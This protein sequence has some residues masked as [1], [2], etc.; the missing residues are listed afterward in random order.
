[1]LLNEDL[2]R[3][4]WQDM[5]SVWTYWGSGTL[6]PCA[7]ICEQSPWCCL[8]TS[9]QS[10][11][12]SE[13]KSLPALCCQGQ[14]DCMP[15]SRHLGEIL[16]QSKQLQGALWHDQLCWD[17]CCHWQKYLKFKDKLHEQKKNTIP[18]SS[19]SLQGLVFLT[20]VTP[21]LSFHSIFSPK[22]IFCLL[23]RIFKQD[24]ICN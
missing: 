21:C 18:L 1:M 24:Q 14:R 19:N 15:H 3:W 5:K 8:S 23:N 22:S 17:I 4:K 12:K 16:N 6:C 9:A 13:P 7:H 20:P 10:L 11:G 2:G